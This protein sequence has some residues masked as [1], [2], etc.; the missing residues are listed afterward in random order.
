M[1]FCGIYILIWCYINVYIFKKGHRFTHTKWNSFC[2]G[3]FVSSQLLMD[4]ILAK[5]GRLLLKV[6]LVHP[7][8]LTW[9]LKITQ[10]KKDNYLPSTSI[11]EFQILISRVY[12]FQISTWICDPTCNSGGFIWKFLT[13]GQKD[14]IGSRFACTCRCVTL[15]LFM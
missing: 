2:Q 5:H 1:C 14:L 12:F 8:K 11:L 7:W 6:L 9:D 10:L 13:K 4:D 15:H 3:I